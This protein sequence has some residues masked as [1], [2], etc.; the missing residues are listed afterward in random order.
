LDLFNGIAEHGKCGRTL[1]DLLHFACLLFEPTMPKD[2]CGI[3]RPWAF[4]V[5]LRVL[6]WLVRFPLRP[7]FIASFDVNFAVRFPV[8]SD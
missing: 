6:K 2:G 3:F 8:V 1:W 4:V 5:A 7:W